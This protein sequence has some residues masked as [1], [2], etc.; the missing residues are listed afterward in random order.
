MNLKTRAAKNVGSNW[1]G[2]FVNM[3]VGFF[4]APFI[5]RKIG[6]EAFGL[7]VLVFSLTGYYGLFDFGVRSSIIRYVAKFKATQDDE[8][9]T[10]LVNTSLFSYSIVSL[11]LLLAT[12][13]ASRYVDSLF[14]VAPAF[15]HTA[16]LLFLMVGAA[17]ALGFPLSV[18]AGIL[19]GLQE[20]F[21]L[22]LTQVAAALLR[23]L[24]IVIA[25]DRGRGLLTIA[26]ISVALG[27]LSYLVYIALVLR[28]L[29]LRIGRRFVN[30]ATFR[31]MMS[32]GIVT[33]GIGLGENL[34]FRSDAAVIGVFLSPAAITHFSIGS[35]LADYSSEVVQSMAQIFTPMSSHF[36]ATGDLESLRK[37]F[38]AGN[39]ACALTTLPL[40][41]GL[42]VLGKPLI[43]VWVGARYLSSYSVLLLLLV[44][45]ALYLAQATSTKILFGMGRHRW[46]AVVLFAE[47]VANLGLSILLLRPLGING[48]ALGT[49]IPLTCTSVLFLP[50]HLCR[51]L[52]VR[53][54]TFFSQVYLLP[55][56]LSAPMVVTLLGMR[57][58]FPAH[59]YA[60]LLTQVVAGA[61]AYALSLLCVSFA[62]QPT[63]AG[64]RT[65]FEHFL[66]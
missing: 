26:L 5:L 55:L 42:I 16:R 1:L 29:P 49:A 14:H 46:L 50:R 54:G 25:L 22:G 24:L 3:A 9:L 15:L 2:L 39:R 64:L 35:K 56:M 36:D 21:W 17:L 20:F 47:G 63:G 40:A 51:L 62:R 65:R 7:W 12:G 4:L 13:L 23:A 58:L 41:A 33:F 37:I 34:R 66:E 31:L 28:V 6:D 61:L 52:N 44:P 60:Q 38:V 53:L 18:F 59:T 57:R 11:M 27:L 30:R 32:Y 43:E 10:R 45:K 19:E 8:Q 48:V